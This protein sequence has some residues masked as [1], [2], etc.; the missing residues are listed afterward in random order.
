MAVET[1]SLHHSQGYPGIWS[2]PDLSPVH[3]NLQNVSI[4]EILNHGS[5]SFGRYEI[6]N[7]AWERYSAFSY[8]RRQEELERYKRPGLVAQ[9]KA[10]FEEYYRTHRVKK[11]LGMASE[12]HHCQHKTYSS[13]LSSPDLTSDRQDLQDAS[14]SQ[15]LDHGS[16][17]LGRYETMVSCDKYSVFSHNTRKEEVERL[18]TPGLVA[19]K[20]AY[21]EEYYGKMRTMKGLQ[22][23]QQESAQEDPLE[24]KQDENGSD[25]DTVVSVEESES[26]NLNQI[27]FSGEDITAEAEQYTNDIVEVQEQNG[28]HSGCRDGT[29]Q[30]EEGED[31]TAETEQC[32]DDIVGE[33]EQNGHYI[34]SRDG[35]STADEGEDIAVE[36]EQCSDDIVEEI[37]QNSHQ[38]GCRDSTSRADEGE[39]IIAETKPYTDDI[40]EENGENGHH[41]GSINESSKA[42]EVEDTP[43]ETTPCT[44]DIADENDQ[45]DH[46]SGCRDRTSQA[47][48]EEDIAAET[49][50]CADDI[51]DEKEQSEATPSVSAVVVEHC[52]EES[53]QSA[54]SSTEAVTCKETPLCDN[55]KKS[56]IQ[57]KEETPS[58]TKL[59]GSNKGVTKKTTCKGARSPV[60]GAKTILRSIDNSTSNNISTPKYINSNPKDFYASMV[61]EN[62]VPCTSNCGGNAVKPS[63]CTKVLEGKSPAKLSVLAPCT[64]K[65]SKETASFGDLR[66]LNPNNRSTALPLPKKS[67]EK[68]A[69]VLAGIHALKEGA[70]KKELNATNDG[71]GRCKK[72]SS[73]WV[74]KIKKALRPKLMQKIAPSPGSNGKD[75]RADKKVT[76]CKPRMPRWRL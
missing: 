19:Q 71:A 25:T 74:T 38:I 69:T 72:E 37:E 36:T 51:V 45:N 10:F 70:Q 49:K 62:L 56:T 50:S 8:D 21:F 18:K 46:H 4:S 73:S 29:S 61:K 26:R 41:N 30:V 5:I 33:K 35:T 57:L 24:D 59:N 17:S 39:D 44:E 63:S 31:V 12:P 9:K 16:I 76:C 13:T 40:V 20:K 48:E 54:T 14:S 27:A 58:V 43:A 68:L 3:E 28:H 66:K 15:M 64:Q 42:D 11:V 6:K 1:A 34:G 52:S 53:L 75:S 60:S 2:C 65:K 7:L 22:A 32:S 55:L 23:K 67:N 47:D